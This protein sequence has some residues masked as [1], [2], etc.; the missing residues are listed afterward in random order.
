VSILFRRLLVAAWVFVLEAVVLV[1]LFPR[2]ASTT[3][4]TVALRPFLILLIILSVFQ[5]AV[6]LYRQSQ[7]SDD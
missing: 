6:A 2:M 5:A 7:N 3:Q 4:I 1:T